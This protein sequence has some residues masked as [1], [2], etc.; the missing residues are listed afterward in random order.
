MSQLKLAL[1]EITSNEEFLDKY[2]V[3]KPAFCDEIVTTCKGGKQAKEAMEIA[4]CL[5]YT[6]Y[7]KKINSIVIENFHIVS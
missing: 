5:G 2:C 4:E 7:D 3:N 1:S 6:K